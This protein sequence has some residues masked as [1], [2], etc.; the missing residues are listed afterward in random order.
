MNGVQKPVEHR[1]G[2]SAGRISPIG[3]A[4]MGTSISW[5]VILRAHGEL[6]FKKSGKVIIVGKPDLEGRF[7]GRLF[8]MPDQ[9]GRLLDSHPVAV[10]EDG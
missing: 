3:E 2:L 10:F 6:L 8:H 7:A 5:T 4:S 9:Q 1:C